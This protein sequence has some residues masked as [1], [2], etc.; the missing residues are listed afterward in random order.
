MYGQKKISNFNLLIGKEI[1]SLVS[2]DHDHPCAVSSRRHLEIFFSLR[3][4]LA[5]CVRIWLLKLAKCISLTQN[6]AVKRE[7]Y[8]CDAVNFFHVTLRC[9]L[10][11][12]TET[13]QVDIVVCSFCS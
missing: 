1:L 2:E 4:F 8:Q 7:Q 13:H 5:L 9:I 11:Q 10:K 12:R 6:Q 3:I